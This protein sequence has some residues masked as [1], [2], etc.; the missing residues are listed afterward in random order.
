V[1]VQPWDA[2]AGWINR[3]GRAVTKRTI[4]IGTMIGA[5]CGVLWSLVLL[6]HQF[7]SLRGHLGAVHAAARVLANAVVVAPLASVLG[8]SFGILAVVGFSVLAGES[9][10]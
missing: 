6:I 3:V 10:A 7:A 9:H 2:M 5:P 1:D 8:I 4:L